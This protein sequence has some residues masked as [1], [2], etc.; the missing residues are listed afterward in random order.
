MIGLQTA[1]ERDRI[2]AEFQSKIEALVR[3][4]MIEQVRPERTKQLLVLERNERY[5][6]GNHYH[7]PIASGRTVDWSSVTG[8]LLSG[9]AQRTAKGVYDYVL[10]YVY[11]DGLK[12]VGILGRA[13]HAKSSPDIN[14]QEN[15]NRSRKVDDILRNLIPHWDVEV[16]Q[17]ALVLSLYKNGTTFGYTPFVNS[18]KRYGQTTVPVYSEKTVE[19]AP[20]RYSC[21]EC[22]W[23]QAV[24]EGPECRSC[25]ITM[26]PDNIAAPEYGTMAQPGGELLAF[27]NG[28]VEFYLCTA[29][30]VSTPYYLKTL[31]DSPWLLYEYEDYPSNLIAAYPQIGP[32]RKE[33]QAAG[34]MATADYDAANA[35]QRAA[36]F[37]GNPSTTPTYLW[38][39]SCLWVTPGTYWTTEDN[40]LRGYLEDNYPSGVKLVS[41]NGK[42]LAEAAEDEALSEVWSACKPC[43]GEYLYPQPLCTPYIRAN[44]LIND[45]YNIM[46]QTAE[47]GI[48]MHFVDPRVVNLKA[49]KQY[50]ASVM[51]F[52]PAIPDAI[53]RLRDAIWST[54]P[55]K[56]NPAV[57][58]IMETALGAAR[59]ITGLLEPL[60]GGQPERQQTLGEAE[61]RRNQA[62]AVHTTTWNHIRS[63]WARC[64]ENAVLQFAKYSA[65]KLYFHNRMGSPHMPAREVEVG[66]LSD[67]MKGGWHIEVDENIPLTFGQ[68]RA[69]WWKLIEAAAQAPMLAQMLGL[70]QP[71]N[72][73]TTYEML[74][75]DSLEIPNMYAR[76]KADQVISRLLQEPPIMLPDGTFAPSVPIDEWEDDHLLMA[77]RVKEWAQKNSDLNDPT[78][79]ESYNP[80]GYQN[81]IAWGKAHLMAHNMSMMPPPM[82]DAPGGGRAPSAGPSSD[83]GPGAAM[84]EG[85]PQLIPAPAPSPR[86][87]ELAAPQGRAA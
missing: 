54:E 72:I 69:Q 82:P 31:D 19:I 55:A 61:M 26:G 44:D 20:E 39:Y 40:M 68:K 74:G 1:V 22:G 16:Q 63:F 78:K 76:D 7:Y 9:P 50:E 75:T 73:S 3:S 46:A 70:D 13:P 28:S 23:D 84:P 35:R 58:A 51:E 41:I 24:S 38:K 8:N 77:Q 10:N 42:V 86:P 21:P 32:R 6:R 62:L 79:P 49:L 4:Q 57:S 43:V 66:D 5:W 56:L 27:D 65:D 18:K 52:Y 83:S 36:T 25:G 47:K 59:Q 81:V 15:S 48:P 67:L 12:L 60:W 34:S 2:A 85:A 53:G 30:T 45:G 87:E 11:G 64:Y 29:Y 14:N 17:M 33:F 37:V 80:L 71:A